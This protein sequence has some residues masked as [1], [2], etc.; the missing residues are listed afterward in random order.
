MSVAVPIVVGRSDLIAITVLE[1]LGR[2]GIFFIDIC[3][4]AYMTIHLG[5]IAAARM[6]GIGI[7]GPAIGIR[8]AYE[9]S[10][11]TGMIPNNIDQ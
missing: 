9:T 5:N 11:I 10:E 1:R 7:A 4:M 6:A 8:V 3:D 2:V